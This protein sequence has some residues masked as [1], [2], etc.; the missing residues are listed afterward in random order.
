MP[1]DQFVLPAAGKT[2]IGIQIIRMI[3]K[4]ILTR[5][6]CPILCVCFTN[7]A[8]DQFLV[9]LLECG[10]TNIV[11]VGGRVRSEK[12][13]KYNL[14]D[15]VYN[16]GTDTENYMKRERKRLLKQTEDEIQDLRKRISGASR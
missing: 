12:L 14:R 10:I 15:K 9:G 11:R 6:G 7:H 2:Y 4:A 16:A 1:H 13:G 3:E 8:L 5:C